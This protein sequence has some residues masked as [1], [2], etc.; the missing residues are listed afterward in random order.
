MADKR[1]IGLT[2]ANVSKIEELVRKG[3]FGAD[4]DAAR[5]AMAFAI[6]HGEPAANAEGAST[7]WNVGSFDPTG[8]IRAVIEASYP[9]TTEPYRLA[10]HLVNRGLDLLFPAPGPAID[11]FETLFPNG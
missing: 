1:T 7:T 6:Q 2:A 4:L 11:V 10:E 5:F 3:H 9:Q 8:E